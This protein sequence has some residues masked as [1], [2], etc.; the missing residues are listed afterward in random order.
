MTYLADESVDRPVVQALRDAGYQ[1]TYV[2]EDMPGAPDPEVLEQASATNSVLLTS[3][4]DFGELVFRRRLSH[5]GVVLLRLS[6]LIQEEKASR[7]VQAFRSHGDRFGDA[8]TVVQPK[9]VR[10][11]G[12]A[13]Q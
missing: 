12:S 5:Q 13:G 10:I 8:F 11:R 3:D 7:A 2:S 4:K 9:R 1:V 6:G